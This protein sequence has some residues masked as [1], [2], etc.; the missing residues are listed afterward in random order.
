LQL[1]LRKKKE[2]D[3]WYSLFKTVAIGERASDDSN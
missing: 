1:T 2:E 3:N